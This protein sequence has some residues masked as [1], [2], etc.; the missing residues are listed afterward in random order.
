VLVEETGAEVVGRSAHQ[1]PEVDG[2]TRLAGADLV[3]AQVGSFIEAIV[4]D[5]EGVDLVA[6][7]VLS[8]RVRWGRDLSE[9]SP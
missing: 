9:G 1:G 7:P 6:E 8:G 4:V 2:S 3:G 5:T